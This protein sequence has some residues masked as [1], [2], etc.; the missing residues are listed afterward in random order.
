MT[1]IDKKL[2]AEYFDYIVERID[3][4]ID[5]TTDYNLEELKILKENLKAN[6]SILL[7]DEETFNS[8]V[9]EEHIKRLRK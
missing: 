9:F 3:K 6:L 4:T 8:I 7:E 2:R 1:L 5:A